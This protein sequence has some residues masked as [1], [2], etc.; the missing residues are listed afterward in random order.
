[1]L[2]RFFFGKQWKKVRARR[3]EK[4]KALARQGVDSDFYLIEKY[5]A[6]RGLPRAESESWSSWLR[7][8][9]EHEKS[10]AKL[11]RVLVLH[12]RHRFDPQGLSKDERAELHREVHA[13]MRE[14][15]K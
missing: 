5:F 10:A 12:Q 8:I 7:R 9:S 13:W 15:S 1:V 3:A 6:S 2:V 4:N 14:M 11:Q